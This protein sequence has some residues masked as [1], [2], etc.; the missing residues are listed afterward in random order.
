M[1]VNYYNNICNDKPLLTTKEEQELGYKIKNGDNEAKEEL[2]EKNLRLVMSIAKKYQGR[3]LD[4]SDLIQEG[5]IGLIIA[6]EKFD[7]ALENKFS[8]YA[9][10]WIKQ[11]ITKAIYNKV[12]LESLPIPFNKVPFNL[13]ALNSWHINNL[14]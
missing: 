11:A 10:F 3:G 14:Y 2:I 4:M 5:C 8:T 12:W 6:V 1:F 7:V 13:A 9:T